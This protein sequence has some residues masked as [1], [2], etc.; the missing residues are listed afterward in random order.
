MYDS[1]P[2]KHLSKMM[3]FCGEANN[4]HSG[5]RFGKKNTV[6]TRTSVSSIIVSN[7]VALGDEVPSKLKIE[8]RWLP[9]ACRSI[10][11]Q[12]TEPRIAPGKQVSPCMAHCMNVC[13]NVL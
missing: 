3:C 1:N 11:A 10:L 2:L 5:Q 8:G 7:T 9:A 6:M 13:V 12:D 4:F